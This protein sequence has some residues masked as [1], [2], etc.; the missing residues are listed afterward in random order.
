[1]KNIAQ[2]NTL[3]VQNIGSKVGAI[4]PTISPSAAYGYENAQ[5]AEGIFTGTIQMP[6]YA[7]MGNPTNSKLESVMS[8]LEGAQAAIATSSGMGAISMV[9]TA[10]LEMGDNVLCIGGF[11][12]GTYTLIQ[13]TLA[14]FGIKGDFCDVDAVGEIEHKIASG[15]IKIVIIESVG[16][17]NLKLPNLQYI[18]DLCNKHNTLIVVDNTLTPL[19]VQPLKMGADIVVYS[20]TKI[21]SGHSAA[22]G[23]IALFRKVEEKDKLHNIKYK[24]LHPILEKT[25]QNTLFA[26]CKKRALRDFGMSAN[27]FGTFLTLLGLE[28][29]ALR[30]E[31]INNNVTIL[32][33]LLKESLH[34]AVVRHPSLQ[35]HEHHDRFIRDYPNGCGSI[36]TIDFGTKE[37]AF[38]FLNKTTLLTQTANI[39]DNRTL[40]LHMRST[41]YRDFT[42]EQC[43]F[44]G[45]TDGL[46]RLSVGLEDPHTIAQDIVEALS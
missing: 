10:L 14:R 3:L 2:F 12:G 11:F 21:L 37:K 4:A 13:E 33:T 17:P 42:P 29:L 43:Q 46:V 6:L 36:L 41:I 22:L 28:T 15:T 9:L 44:L 25:K 34:N 5:E 27:A 8:Q 32:A 20:S 30:T 35:T 26:I 23:G 7:R 19:L 45:I 18:I 39:G 40:A 31:R 1:M 38:T 16:N 24:S